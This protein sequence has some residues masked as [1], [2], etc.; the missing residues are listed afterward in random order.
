MGNRFG[1]PL[2]HH[3]VVVNAVGQLPEMLALGAEVALEGLYR[4]PAKLADGANAEPLKDLA[5]LFA[6]TPQPFNRKWI[7]KRLTA[8]AA[9]RRSSWDS[10]RWRTQSGFVPR[11][12]AV[13]RSQ[14]W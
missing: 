1:F 6:D 5:P 14:R 10:I 8:P 4:P 3:W 9:A 7:E 13:P 12:M 2:R 11:Q